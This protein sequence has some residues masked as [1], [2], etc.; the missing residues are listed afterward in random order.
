MALSQVHRLLR[1]E[2]LRNWELKEQRREQG[3]GD[4]SVAFSCT[5]QERA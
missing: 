2:R 1:K 3:V 5:A 4:T